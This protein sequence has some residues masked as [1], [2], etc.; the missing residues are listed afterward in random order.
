[1]D[2]GLLHWF[3]WMFGMA[4]LIGVFGIVVNPEKAGAQWGAF[5]GNIVRSYNDT[6][7]GV[8]R[9]PPEEKK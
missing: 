7:Q 5:F 6:V 1:M 9:D 2:R 4:V 3:I 8:R